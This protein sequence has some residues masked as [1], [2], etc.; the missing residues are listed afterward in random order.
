MFIKKK[1]KCFKAGRNIDVH[2][3]KTMITAS[4]VIAKHRLLW[5]KEIVK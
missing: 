4:M 3:Q 2:C 1:Q 5:H